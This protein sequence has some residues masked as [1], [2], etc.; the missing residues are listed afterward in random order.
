MHKLKVI[1]MPGAPF[2]SLASI[3][4]ASH[5]VEPQQL[6]VLAATWMADNYSDFNVFLLSISSDELPGLQRFDVS[7]TLTS[8]SKPTFFRCVS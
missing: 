1:V 3:D 6:G 5:E 7:L 2:V 4:T 8:S